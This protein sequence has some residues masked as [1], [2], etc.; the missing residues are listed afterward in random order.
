MKVH[1]YPELPM[2]AFHDLFSFKTENNMKLIDYFNNI[3]LVELIFLKV[4][5]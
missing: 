4:E 5:K 1:S 3:T 2:T